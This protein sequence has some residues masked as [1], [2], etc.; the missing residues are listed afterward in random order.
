MFEVVINAQ[1]NCLISHRIQINDAIFPLHLIIH[2]NFSG[3]VL[4]MR[5]LTCRAISSHL[6][7]C[8]TLRTDSCSNGN[9]TLTNGDII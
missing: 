9:N 8:Q 5:I 1:C 2:V 7:F 3:I 4:S 6:E